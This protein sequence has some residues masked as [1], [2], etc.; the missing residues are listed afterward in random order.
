MRSMLPLSAAALTACLLSAALPA[1]A[2]TPKPEIERAPGAP[3]AVGTAHTLRTI[4]EACARLEGTFTGNAAAPYDFRA[5][6]TSASCQQRAALVDPAKAKPSRERG[7]N[8]ND[9]IVVPRAGCPSQRAVVPVWRKPAD[10]T[11]PDLDG[12]GRARIYLDESMQKIAS[13]DLAPVPMY[14][15][16]LTLQGAGCD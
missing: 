12:Q 10:A 6:R 1:T 4:T 5:V 8:L 15:A 13:G 9:V 2:A 3:Q 11:P 16:A 14:S 7:W